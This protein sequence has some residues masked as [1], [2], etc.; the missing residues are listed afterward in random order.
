MSRG[1]KTTPEVVYQIMTSWAV[2]NNYAETARALNLATSTV[3]K[4]VDD[5]KDKDEFVRLRDECKMDFAKKATQIIDKG[6]I[7]L[8]NRF[9]RALEQEDNLD[10]LI[11]A[12]FDSDKTELTQD[13][14]KQLVSKI[15][16]LQLQDIKAITTAIGTLFDKRAL[17]QGEATNN[18]SVSI[19][20]PEG[21][22]DY[23]G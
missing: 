21:F 23:A 4:V 5:N 19:T 9:E 16:A 17:A 6:M 20:L 15:R 18:T 10:V 11:D 7:L 14:K 8:N 2:T 1:K 3:K 12:I 13:D 22:D